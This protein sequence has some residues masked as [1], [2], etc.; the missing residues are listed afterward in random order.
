[1]IVQMSSAKRDDKAAVPLLHCVLP[2]YGHLTQNCGPHA[3]PSDACACLLD[4]FNQPVKRAGHDSSNHTHP[5]PSEG[6]QTACCQNCQTRRCERRIVWLLCH[7][8]SA[9]IWR[10]HLLHHDVG[11]D[12]CPRH[13]DPLRATLPLK[14]PL[15]ASPIDTMPS[16]LRGG[17]ANASF[18]L[19]QQH[20]VRDLC[21]LT[22]FH[23]LNR[24]HMESSVGIIPD[25]LHLKKIV[26]APLMR[27]CPTTCFFWKP[28]M[29]Y[30]VTCP[31][32][33]CH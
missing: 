33:H 22:D 15:Q 4:N 2:F 19:T 18:M 10:C 28:V 27:A 32:P 16:V 8:P 29:S 31:A 11:L 23:F 9:C 25:F 17:D 12:I 24:N 26:R 1:M 7:I 14:A 13:S 30:L 20:L 21:D 6:K 3:M 5:I